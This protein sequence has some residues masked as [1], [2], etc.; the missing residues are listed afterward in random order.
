MS[1]HMNWLLV[2]IIGYLAIQLAVGIVVSRRIRTETDYILAGRSLGV[3]LAAFS[4]FATWFGAESI[5]GAAG[6]LY[7]DG[8]SGGSADPFGYV[9]CILLVGLIYARPLWNRGFTTFGDLF[10]ERYSVT[11]ERLAIVLMVPTSILWGAAQIRAFGNIVAHASS[12]PLDV[13]IT[14][15]ALFVVG[16][17]A[18]GGLLADAWT[19]VV[20]GIAIV[21]GLA[22]LAGTLL[23]SGALQHAWAQVPPERLAVLGSPETPWYVVLEAW[24]VPVVGSMLAI[25]I[26]S[27]VLGC[28]S[29]DTARRACLVGGGIYLVVGL[30]PAILGLCGPSLVPGIEEAEQV[31]P[32]LARLHLNT[33]AYILFSGALISAILSTVDSTLLAGSALLTHNVLLQF[34]PDLSDRSK[35]LWSRAGVLTLGVGAWV[36]ALISHSISDLVAISSSFG[37][38][39]IFVVGTLGLFTSIGGTASA[40]AA[41]VTGMVVWAAGAFLLQWPAPYVSA[42]VASVVAYLVAAP[43]HRRALARV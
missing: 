31:I 18:V 7:T 8:L 21:V 15:A 36:L 22:V 5:Q 23:A 41:L 43:L 34:W 27:R 24:V 11:V 9:A 32:E 26:I 6:S 39:G 37:S 38:A 4:I 40:L 20:Q 14:G 42:V 33:A 29:A 28:R 12:M 3:G 35:L 10:R 2:G 30:I 19:D 16:Y 17:S 25:E 13:A 1:S